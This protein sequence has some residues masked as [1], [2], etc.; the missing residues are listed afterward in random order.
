MGGTKRKA[1]VAASAGH[2]DWPVK[3]LPSLDSTLQSYKWTYGPR[4][5]IDE[6]EI[7]NKIL[8]A[9]HWVRMPMLPWPSVP[10][11]HMRAGIGF[12]GM[13][14]SCE[15]AFVDNTEKR[16]ML[17]D[18]A[19]QCFNIEWKLEVQALCVHDPLGMEEL[20]SVQ[21]GHYHMAEQHLYK[22]VDKID[23]MHGLHE[24]LKPETADLIKRCDTAGLIKRSMLITNEPCALW[25]TDSAFY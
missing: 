19:H 22:L 9:A 20:R 15:D 2:I 8:E 23:E 16:N 10:V 3:A 4:A 12:L 18:R 6:R 13:Y 14:M 1:P 17:V 11:E 7:V 25:L 21:Y 24:A 5:L